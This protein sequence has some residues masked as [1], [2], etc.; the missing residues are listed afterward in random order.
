M[1]N[2]IH[3]AIGRRLARHLLIAGALLVPLLAR[4]NTITIR[5]VTFGA[6]VVTTD[7]SARVITSP[8]T[9]LV[10]GTITLPHGS[11]TLPV[12]LHSVLLLDP[13]D[14]NV[15]DFLTLNVS[16]RVNGMQQVSLLFES[17]AAPGFAAAVT[18]LRQLRGTQTTQE[19]AGLADLSRFLDSGSLSIRL[20]SG[21]RGVP[22]HGSTLLLLGTSLLGIYG[23]VWRTK[24]SRSR[25]VQTASA[26]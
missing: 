16:G 5:G 2:L 15:S 10:N 21:P 1:K 12:G 4:P 19:T 17:D 18:A 14:N 26:I 22:D 24:Y 7:W 20:D 9:A 25:A 3:P 8:D 13:A 23:F 6:P 11:P